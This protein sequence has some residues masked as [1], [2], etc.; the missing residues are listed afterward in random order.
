MNGLTQ[1]ANV[2]LFV[3]LSAASIALYWLPTIIAR[4]RNV[5]GLGQV[6]L[7]NL[8]FGLT[9]VGWVAALVMAYREPRPRVAPAIPPGPQRPI[10]P[11]PP[12]GPPQFPNR[13]RNVR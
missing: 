9:I 3:A 8:F 4:H 13:L 7:V 1:V 10:P 12:E 2:L 5:R 11:A 6:V